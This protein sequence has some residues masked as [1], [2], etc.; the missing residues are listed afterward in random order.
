VKRFHP[1][2]LVPHPFWLLLFAFPVLAQL[3]YDPGDW[4]S[5]RDLRYARALDAGAQEL[6]IATSAGLLEY[7]LL[8]RTWSDPIV[9]GY[10]LSAPVELDDPMLLLFD[11]QT[12]YVW[13]AT[14]T[15]LLIYDV[16]GKRWRIV[17]DNLWPAGQR[18][19]NI[20]VGGTYVFV[21]TVPEAFY[22]SFFPLD[23]PIPNDKWRMVITRYRG[24]RAFGGLSLDIDPQE[25]GEI[26][27]RGLRSKR[28]LTSTELHG[29]MG[30]PPANFPSLLL[31][32]GWVW[33]A[34]GMLLDPYFRGVPVTDWLVDQFG[35]L[36]ATFW[37]GGIMQADLTVNSIRFYRAGPAGNDIRAL[38]VERDEIWMGGFNTGD[39]TGITRAE[40]DLKSWQ[41]YEPRDNS[42]IRSTEVFD[43]T[44]WDG[45]TWF[46][47]EE[48]LLAYQKKGA[49]W[50]LFTVSQNLQSDQI[51]ALQPADSELWI[52]NSR[53]LCF[54]T[55]V[56]REIWRA[57]NGGIELGGVTD[58]ALCGDTLYV[59]TGAGL[60][61]GNVHNRRFAFSPLDPGLLNAA[62]AEI[63]T[64]GTEVWLV[65]AEGVQVYNQ[66][67]GQS[68]S[69]Y[70][71][72][73]LEKAEPACICAADSFVWVG[74]RED[75]FFRYR[76]ATGEWIHYTTVDGLLDNRVQVIRRDG[77]D[78]LIGTASGLTRFYWNRP[79]RLR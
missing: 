44:F 63:S 36:W 3:S 51:R 9:V 35:T 37:G 76:R 11:E 39:R 58:L 25:I 1:S 57:E 43:I 2:F 56:G 12:G 74:T 30:A 32:G 4:T 72:V 48:G 40:P 15:K 67:N 59:G 79:G 22:P 8:R 45:D 16:D 7:R 61:K 75:G 28:P 13:L 46:A 60:F 52:G 55:Q 31:D 10:G 14:K 33:H 65:T 17:H 64:Y 68:K 77:D 53:G 6:Y 21:E 23:S 20:G 18:V 38:H 71:D 49:E 26:R 24:A 27:W 69:W 50:K 73:W 47:T 5:Y 62:I 19:V 41:F 70:A 66:A 34:D 78:L 29:Y 42:R 54:M